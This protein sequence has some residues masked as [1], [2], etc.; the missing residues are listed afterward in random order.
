MGRS[1]KPLGLGDLLHTARRE[2]ASMEWWQQL[3]PRD[4]SC[5]HLAARGASPW[6][7]LEVPAPSTAAALPKV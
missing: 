7:A 2:A 1:G 6:G 3:A 4:I 5:W